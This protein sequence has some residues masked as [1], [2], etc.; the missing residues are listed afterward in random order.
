VFDL[1]TVD[2]AN[3][4]DLV[5]KMAIWGPKTMNVLPENAYLWD[6]YSEIPDT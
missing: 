5:A 3:R 6:V 4:A 2:I 1:A